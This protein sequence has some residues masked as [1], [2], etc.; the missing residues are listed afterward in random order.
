M[1]WGDPIPSDEY[2][3]NTANVRGGSNFQVFPLFVPGTGTWSAIANHVYLGRDEM[4]YMIQLQQRFGNWDNGTFNSLMNWLVKD[5]EGTRPYWGG[6][7]ESDKAFEYGT[8]LWGRQVVEIVG[9][10]TF[11]TTTPRNDKSRNIRMGK[12]RMFTRADFEIAKQFGEQITPITHPHLIPQCAGAGKG[13]KFNPTPKGYT[14]FSP[15]WGPEWGRGATAVEA[16]YAPFEYLVK[17]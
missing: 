2:G 10:A 3:L 11:K 9:E 17:I 5:G 14:M 16:Y 12:V 7:W 4:D 15:L 8:M 6:K 1:A 13:N